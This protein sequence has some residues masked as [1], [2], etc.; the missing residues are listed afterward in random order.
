LGFLKN[1]NETELSKA[2]QMA[3]KIFI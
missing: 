3:S 2:I 1:M